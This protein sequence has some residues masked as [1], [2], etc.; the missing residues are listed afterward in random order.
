MRGSFLATDQGRAEYWERL[1]VRGAAESMIGL[2][3]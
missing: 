3:E 2:L 1:E